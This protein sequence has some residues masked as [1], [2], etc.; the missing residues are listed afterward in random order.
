MLQTYDKKEFQR[1]HSLLSSFIPKK[2]MPVLASLD[3]K[4][5]GGTLT[6]LFSNRE[7]NDLDLYFPSW[8]AIEIFIAYAMSPNLL[9]SGDGDLTSDTENSDYVKKAFRQFKNLDEKGSYAKFKFSIPELLKQDD[10]FTDDNI[11]LR[12]IGMTDKS[13]M[14]S[15]CGEGPV[16][17]C[18]CFDTFEDTQS[19]FDKFDYTI[20]MGAYE[21]KTEK[22]VFDRDFL[23]HIAQ[24]VLVLNPGTDYPIV[25]MLRSAKYQAR[26]YT[27]S[28]REI[29]KLGLACSRLDLSSWHDAKEH[30][31]GMYGAN[32]E[33]LFNDQ[34]DFS[35]DLLFDKLDSAPTAMI[36]S[37]AVDK[38]KGLK[39]KYNADF[40]TP[41]EFF[42]ILQRLRRCSGRPYFQ[43]VYGVLPTANLFLMNK[44]TPDHRV[45]LLDEVNAKELCSCSYL[46]LSLNDAENKFNGFSMTDRNWKSHIEGTLVKVCVVKGSDLIDLSGMSGVIVHS[47]DEKD[48]YFKITE[49]IDSKGEL[50]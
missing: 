32:V 48:V 40:L 49:I 28:R 7:V 46:Y 6:S 4:I 41:L 27:I 50:S 34:R 14:F 35:F 25:S 21:F 9:L 15:T 42:Q 47:D 33:K 30:L 38:E 24:R 12:N 29:M 1:E 19:I 37:V 2:L 22:W 44:H 31:S 39:G 23:K 36:S 43:E 20:N 26:G 18:I 45:G 5:A 8:E 3:V 11:F 13:V 17:Q 16:I 10:E